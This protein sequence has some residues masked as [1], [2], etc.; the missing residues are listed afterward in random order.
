MLLHKSVVAILLLNCLLQANAQAPKFTGK[1]SPYIDDNINGFWEY[2]PRNYTVDAPKRYPLLIFIHGSG[3]QGSTQDMAT[4]NLVLRNGTPKIIQAG[5]FPDSFKVN[6]S[7]YKFI[8]LCPQI[9]VGLYGASS[10][11]APSTIEA[12]ISYAK[13]IYRVDT[14]RIYL[15]G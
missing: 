9:K 14:T 11:I 8:V 1:F 6:G 2:L 12:L 5:T 13:A 4:L 15:S 10:I 7:W 3:E